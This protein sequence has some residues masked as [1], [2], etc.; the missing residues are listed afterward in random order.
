MAFNL[1]RHGVSS[2]QPGFTFDAASCLVNIGGHLHRVIWSK[3]HAC[4]CSTVHTT[5]LQLISRAPSQ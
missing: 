4:P 2:V 1:G 3:F 5:V